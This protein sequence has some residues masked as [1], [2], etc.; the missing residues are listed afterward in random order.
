[1]ATPHE[2][3]LHELMWRSRASMGLEN[4]VVLAK[5]VNFL[6]GN[7]IVCQPDIVAIDAL[8]KLYI[9]EYKG[10]EDTER[11]ARKQLHAAKSFIYDHFGLPVRTLY[12]HGDNQSKEI[13]T[14]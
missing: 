2:K 1:M 12:V 4:I 14:E 8:G 13:V 11:K 10:G 5:E 3:R 6:K 9:V 7:N